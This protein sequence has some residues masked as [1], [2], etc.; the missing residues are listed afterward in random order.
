M[1]KI[2]ALLSITLLMMMTSCG[3]NSDSGEDMSDENTTTEST[4][5]ESEN[6]DFE[7]L[8]EEEI[9]ALFDDMMRQ[10]ELELGEDITHDNDSEIDA[11]IQQAFEQMLLIDEDGELNPGLVDE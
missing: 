2:V 5:Q 3:S 4:L 6:D 9:Q 1:K 8:S 11:D 7:E 10:V